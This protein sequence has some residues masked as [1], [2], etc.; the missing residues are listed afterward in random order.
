VY[1]ATYTVMFAMRAPRV[2]TDVNVILCSKLLL[3]SADCHTLHPTVNQADVWQPVSATLPAPIRRGLLPAPVELSFAT[4]P[5]VV[6]DLANVQLVGPDGRDVV[7]NGAFADG[8]TRWF[9]TSDEH[10]LWRILNLPLSIWFEG[11][12]LGAVAASLLVLAAIGGAMRAIRRGDPLG[13]PI[14]GAMLAV[15]LCG[16]FDNIFEAPRI[17]LLFDLVALLGLMLGWPP[18]VVLPQPQQTPRPSHGARIIHV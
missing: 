12:V 1:G 4:G 2:G 14:A 13:A 16:C 6:L 18:H 5:G 8:T 9:F 3:Y 15:L 11:G 10:W 7:T 17:A